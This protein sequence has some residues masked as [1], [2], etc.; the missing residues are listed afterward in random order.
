V[1]QPPILPPPP[2]DALAASQALLRFMGTLPQPVAFD[3]FMQHALYHPQWGYYTG[4]AHKFG[5][6]GDFTTAPEMTPL[7]GRTLAAQVA[8]VLRDNTLNQVLEFGAGSGK[9][10]AQVLQALRAQ[11]LAPGYAI[12]DVSGSLRARQAQTIA[13]LAPECAQQVTWLDALPDAFEGVVLANE[14]LDAMPC[15]L[16]RRS[17]AGWNELCVDAKNTQFVERATDAAPP[18]DWHAALPLGY[19]TEIHPQADAFMATLGGWLKRGAALFIDYGFPEA[20]F[21]H[22]QRATGTLMCHYQQFAHGDALLWPG[23]QDI[24]CHVNF[25]GAALAAQDADLE[26]LGYTSQ[27]RFLLNCGVLNGLNTDTALKDKS[28]VQK[29]L[30]EHEMGELFKVLAVGRKLASPLVGFAAG[31]RT[32]RL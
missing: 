1:E 24:T 12:L 5:A 14:L 4:G 21:Y 23:L 25:T 8:Q 9:L 17:E 3:V 13:Q 16:L 22:P 30:A 7:F 11:G 27:A 6:G 20:E 32:H 31:D 29:L 10:A 19:T 28:A 18:V 26:V 15:K 2:A